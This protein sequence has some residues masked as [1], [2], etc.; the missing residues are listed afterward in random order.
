MEKKRNHWYWVYWAKSW[1]WSDENAI[2]FRLSDEQ[3]EDDE[4]IA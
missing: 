1:S 4:D 3:E 2:D